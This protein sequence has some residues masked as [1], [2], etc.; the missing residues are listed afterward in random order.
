MVVCE[1]KKRVGGKRERIVLFII[2]LGSLY[3]FIG[4]YVKVKF[5]MY[6]GWVIK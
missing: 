4:L 3:Y 2:L 5:E 6:V 1:E